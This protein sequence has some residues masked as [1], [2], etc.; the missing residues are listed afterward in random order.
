M[1]FVLRCVSS[2]AEIIARYRLVL[3]VGVG[4]GLVSKA[5]RTRLG[6][7]TLFTYYWYYLQG[8]L[9]RGQLREYTARRTA[10]RLARGACQE[11]T[12]ARL[13]PRRARAVPTPPGRPRFRGAGGCQA[14]TL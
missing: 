14:V 8:G 1:A 12:D 10:A 4:L 13:P 3:G 2:S 7:V 9:R 11:P 5:C 6:R